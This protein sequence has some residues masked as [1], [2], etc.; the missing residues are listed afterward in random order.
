MATLSQRILDLLFPPRCV[1]CGA[2]GAVLCIACFS[3]IRAPSPPICSRCGRTVSTTPAGTTASCSS[4]SLSP[5]L[6]LTGLRAASVYESAVRDAILALKFRGQRRLADPLAGVLATA[7][8][9][10]SLAADLLVAVPLHR[11][12][13][14]AR[15]FN[16]AELLALAL[17]QR[18]HLPARESLVLRQRETRA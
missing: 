4:C 14:R 15:G 17:G 6:H 11:A 10:E 5:L 13:R 8:A 18:L 3:K 1:S 16:Q 2:A 12:R 9:R 7:Y